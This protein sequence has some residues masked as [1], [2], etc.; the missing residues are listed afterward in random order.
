MKLLKY[1][2]CFLKKGENNMNLFIC[3]PKCSTCK[4]A[5]DFLINNNVKYEKR[6]IKL[7]NP[8]KEELDNFV[9]LSNKDIKA[10]FNTSGLVYKELNLKDKLLNMTYEDKL[11]ILSSNGMLVK[12]PIMVTRNKVYVGFNEK[13][14]KDLIK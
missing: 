5:E 8:T 3:Y 7:N 13:D 1:L 9:K 4:K 2:I 6:D 12:R 10:F 14:W 11:N